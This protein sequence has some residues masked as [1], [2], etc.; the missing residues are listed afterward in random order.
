MAAAKDYYAIL[1]V[2]K[3]AGKDEI[4]TAYRKLARKYHPDLNPGDKSSEEKFKEINEAYSVLSDSKKREQ[5]D[6][7]G[8]APEG[9]FAYSAPGGFGA[10]WPGGGYGYEYTTGAEGDSG[11]AD[12]LSELFG[13]GG[14]RQRGRY[15]GKG[16]DL[17]TEV[18]VSFDEAFNGTGRRMNFT[19]EAPCPSCGGTGALE[20]KR[21]PRCGGTGRLASKKGFFSSHQVCPECGGTG[22]KASK[23]CPSCGGAG[24]L[25]NN[26]TITVKIPAGVDEGSLVK[27]KGMG[28]AGVN[29]GPP[30]D[31]HIRVH[32]RPHPFFKR[33]GA[34]I[35]LQLPVTIGE[36]ALGAKVEVPT[37]EGRTVIMKIPPGTQGGQRFKLK[38]KGFI[39]PRTKTR[40]DMYVDALIA[41]P[42]RL[43]EKE[44]AALMEVESAYGENPRVKAF[45]SARR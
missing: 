20:I 5:Y 14:A 27:L 34:D 35:Y 1:G 41:V 10:Q 26:E 6:K 44:R 13:G 32:V 43:G 42:S 36:A 45:S 23:I 39:N 16:E 28:N 15:P 22:Q 3:G 30:G 7:F 33:E 12:I 19:R 21:C 11:F 40:G 8:Q 24:K 31:L 18:E 2:S 38:G 17:I 29:G 9:G 25:T 37:P 4:K